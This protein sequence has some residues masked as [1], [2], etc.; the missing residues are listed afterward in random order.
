[1]SG[2]GD[3]YNKGGMVAF[4]A[5]FGIVLLFMGYVTFVHDGVDLDMTREDGAAVKMAKKFN[6]NS[7]EKPWVSSDQLVEHGQ[8]VY[9]NNC[10]SCHG[11]VGAGDGPAAAGLNPKPRNLVAGDWKWG[12]D[13]IGLFKTLQNGAPVA[14]S[15]MLGYKAML[16]AGDRWSIVHY[17]QSITKNKVAVSADK[18]EAFAKTAE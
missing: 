16:S 5:A 6:P 3:H 11:P 4:V 18:V 7:V 9:V 8:K 10:A 15:V 12:G 1:M 17:I 2:T 14:G 13:A